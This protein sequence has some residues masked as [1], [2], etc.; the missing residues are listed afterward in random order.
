MTPEIGKIAATSSQT[1]NAQ[2]VSFSLADLNNDTW[3][4]LLAVT[5]SGVQLFPG[6]EGGEFASDPMS[7]DGS[8]AARSL[9]INDANQ[10]GFSIF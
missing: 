1:I 6:L 9:S 2:A 5:S 8:S 7:L 10:D 4:D 3:T